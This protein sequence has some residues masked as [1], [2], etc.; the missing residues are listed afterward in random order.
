MKKYLLLFCLLYN[1]IIIAFESHNFATLQN[2]C[3][4]NSCITLPANQ[5]PTTV[6]VIHGMG[7]SMD[8]YSSE[9]EYLTGN[10]VRMLSFLEDLGKD[11]PNYQVY[12][13]DYGAGENDLQ[14]HTVKL[15][16]LNHNST[17]C[18]NKN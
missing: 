10:F 1:Q 5:P 13:I 18:N 11:Q 4:Q 6:L 9:P 7:S 2:Y 17:T 3:Q 12:A 14:D 16:R 15:L 8:A